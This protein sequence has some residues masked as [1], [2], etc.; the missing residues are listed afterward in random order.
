MHSRVER[1]LRTA[2]LALLALVFVAAPAD[3]SVVIPPADDDLIVHADAV[4][5]GRVTDIESHDNGLGRLSTFITFAIDEVLKGSVAQPTLT[6]RELGGQVGGMAGWIFANPEFTVGERVLLFLDQRADGTLRVMH[7][8]LGKFSIVTDPAS[9]DLVA[10]RPLP[11]DVTVVPPAGAAAAGVALGAVGRGLEEFKA[12]I[13]EKAGEARPLSARPSLALPLASASMPAGISERHQEFRFLR[14]PNP[15]AATDPNLVQPR[16]SQPDT[17]TPIVMQINVNGEPLAP[18]GS[19]GGREQVRAAFRAWSRVPTSSFHYVEG[20]A[21]TMSGFNRDFVNVVS[22]RDPDGDISP[23]SGCSGVLAVGG[24]FFS[25]TPS[26]TVGGRQFSQ[27]V[28]ADLVFAD[29]WDACTFLP[30]GGYYQNF[31]NLTEVA[32]HELGHAL[33]LGHSDASTFDA[34]T[35]IDGATMEPFAHFDGRGAGLHT[36]DRNGVSFIYPGRTLTIVKSGGGS[37]TITSGTAGINCGADCVA[38]FAPNSNV[39]LTVTPD[40]G[41]TFSGF[42]GTGCSTTVSMSVDRTCTATFTTEPD[43]VISAISG[44]AVAAPGQTIVLNNTVR[45]NGLPA[46]A[47]NVGLYLA[48]AAAVTTGDRQLT[49]RRVTGGL[50]T[51]AT[52]A[53][54]T[55]VQIPS[56]VV[57][58]NYFLG[59][60]ADIDDEVPAEGSETNNAASTPI[61][62]AQ[63]DLV[64]TVLTAPATAGAGL[65]ITVSSTVKN[66]AT[67]AVTAAASTLAFYLSPDSTFDPVRLAETRAIGTLAKDAVSTGPTTLTIPAATAPGSYVLIAAA[68]DLGVV[69]E[70]NEANNTRTAPMAISR[71]DLSVTS[72]AVTPTL[73]AAGM[74]VSVT[75]VVKNLALAPASAPASTSRL[76]LSSN[77]TLGD[78]DDVDLGTVSIPA[79]AAAAQA[80]V[81]KSVVIPGGT[82]P[83]LYWIFARANEGD[84]I[85]EAG[86][87][88]N[89][90]ARTA[91]PITIGPDLIVTT[92]TAA[93]TALAPGATVNVTNTVKNQGG[94]TTL[95]FDVGIYL[96]ANA[97]YEA[98][99]DTLLATRRVPA[100]LGAGLSAGPIATQV[101]IPA[102]TPADTYFLIVRADAS[103]TQ[104]NGEVLEVNESNNNLAT[105]AIQVVKPDL[106]VTSVTATPVALVAG[107]NISVT[108]VV[109]NLAL[110]P[111]AAAAS[112][113]RLYL[114]TDATLDEPGDTVLGDVAVGPLAG[115]AMATVVKGVTIPV[116]TVPGLYWIIARANATSSVP[117]ADAP[118]QANNVKATAAPI[119]VG[120]DLVVTAAAPTPATT[121]PGLTVSVSNTVKNQGGLAA[122]P[123][124]V[125]VYLSTDNF[126]QDGVDLFLGSR[127]VT[128]LTTTLPSTGT[129]PVVIPTNQPA[130]NYFLIV[131]ADST[132]SAPGEVTEAN[133]TNNTLAIA[134][135]VAR[136]DLA[137]MSVTAPTVA[138]AGM[139]V[140]VT[141]VVKNLAALA[142]GAPATFSRLFLSADATL[143][144][145]DVQL[146]ADVPV[147]A[148]AGGG[149]ASVVRSV[150]IPPGTPPGRYYVIA[151]ANATGTVVEADT[152]TLA[153]NVRATATP[154][155]IGPDLVVTAA[156]P[157]PAATAPGMTVNVTNT[158]KNQ[159]G[160][161]AGSFTVGIYLSDDNVFDGGDTLLNSRPV[162]SLAAGMVSGPLVTPV[163]IPA[164]Q[165]AGSYFLIVRVDNAGTPGFVSEANEA[166]N[167]LAVPLTVVQPD[168][169]VQSVTVTPPAI[170][171][172]GNVSV[173]HVVKNL[174]VLAGAA[175]ASTSRLYLS[176]DATLD[177]PGDV[178]LGDVAVGAKGGGA[179]TTLTKSVQVPIGTAPGLYWII[180][181]ANATNSVLEI[182]SPGQ[183]NNVKAMATP[184]VVG[185]DVLVA[186]ASTVAR[187]TPGMNV[188]VTY[189]LKNR[190]G[191]AANNFD[192]GFSLVP[193]PSGAEIPLG[194]SRTGVSLI[195]GAMSPASTNT[196]TIPP[197]TALGSY[198]IKV[199]ADASATVGEADE[200][201]NTLLTGTLSVL[202]P[203]LNVPTVTFTPAMIA[204]GGNISVSHVVKNLSLAPGNAGLSASRLL[205]STDQ[206][207][208]GQV[209]DLGTVNVPSIVA[210][211]MTTVIRPAQVPVGLPPGR[212]FVLAQADEADVVLEQNPTNNLGAS[213]ARLVVGPDMTV[214]TASTVAGAI[215]GANVSVSYTLK[216]TG[217]AT[218][219]FDV[220]FVL[221]PVSPG[222]D[223]PIGPTRTAVVLAT[224]GT[225]ASSST[226]GVPP[227]VAAGQYRIRVTA[228]PA[229]TV[230]EAVETN[231]SVTTGIVTITPPELSI[232][233]LSVPGT[234]I[235]GRS[236]GIPNTVVNTAAA[237]GTAP[238]FQVGLYLASSAVIDPGS[239]TLLV[240]RPVASL[241][242]AATS[243]ATS[244]VTL[245]TTPG[246]YFIGAVADRGGAV[247][248][249]NDAN[250]QMS[251]AIAVVPN[252]VRPST[253]ASAQLTLSGCG[254][255][256][257]NGSANLGGTFVVPTQ[258][259]AAWGGTVRLVSGPQINTM[260][261]AGSVTVAGALSGT[262]TIVNSGGARGNG[263]FTGTVATPGS[264]GAVAATFTGSFTVNE[265]CSISGSFSSP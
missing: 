22:F 40:S 30:G 94:P 152:P 252:M 160:T 194:P 125:S 172:G 225:L 218:S 162:L 59:A 77:T 36:D 257:N 92:A 102:N 124:D 249:A 39:T 16:F 44:P 244:M 130:G 134:L 195:A 87:A 235:A 145:G 202:R 80:S 106:T 133:E 154:I 81:L 70:S 262:F 24:M 14:D 236:V 85:P 253:T 71:P 165:P 72:V 34:A 219:A 153:N 143:D 148:L 141:H 187:A 140:S 21:T 65:T 178:V 33:G 35:G 177:D 105:I 256:A 117:E 63:S 185:P 149:M 114:S 96:S 68:D 28:E 126:Y 214:T 118:A 90:A 95:G 221:V 155:T 188:S 158:V 166:N 157:A 231:N 146:G 8:Y 52:S 53:E 25:A 74:N 247:V 19:D 32:T 7:L 100:G 56:D 2:L 190:G 26:M 189:A 18:A 184:I 229:D 93:P 200:S 238:A 203:D 113:S 209:A 213:V 4:I 17:N 220:G 49:T 186:S 196:V 61:L 156:T 192:V 103:G 234:G 205:L 139:N 123:F 84:T 120:P 101:T 91:Q 251:G 110:L 210:G 241:A 138:A 27:A 176:N 51:N 159:G 245:P 265:I 79:L 115:A 207:I 116:G 144:G 199:T 43:L 129:I 42:T 170:A 211:G 97:T 47:F 82:Q 57:P 179:I 132:G 135:T 6:I 175:P 171:P 163:V 201:N 181:R 41:S 240:S 131:R 78:G 111:G 5:L 193:Q 197:G 10:V 180:A 67:A 108:H 198:K 208:A 29:G 46:G 237:P 169:T 54:A 204:P 233:S 60:I 250:N 86:G 215:P 243:A 12:R 258:T 260:T 75:Q 168:L 150:L 128:G 255:A 191:Q 73:A 182:D 11:E 167:G 69:G 164:N 20:A 136:A 127:R 254:V 66:Q 212:Y 223:V 216:N 109:K 50:G 147:G 224:N 98:G 31:S 228:D 242:P 9:G 99:S 239:D 121:A 1:G 13:R 38:G 263:S 248:E 232:Q 173:T 64:V 89:N 226:V 222:P 230:V 261:I 142:G 48:S 107:A 246:N 15:P 161:G 37:G 83:G 217:S 264:P 55:S 206:T 227:G 88:G 174:A 45:N 3:A 183:A 62:I 122:G 23:P 58:G 112:T 104:P 76:T 259:A 119:I 151:Q 137:V